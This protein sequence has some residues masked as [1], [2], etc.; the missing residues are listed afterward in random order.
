MPPKSK[1]KRE[2]VLAAAVALVRQSGDV[3]LN[4]R[5]IA[6][7]LHCS[8][9]PIF[10]NFGSMEEVRRAVIAEAM[11]LYAELDR[12]VLASEKYPVYKA[13]GMAY[14]GFAEKEPALFRLLYMRSRTGEQSSPEAPLFGQMANIVQQNTGLDASAAEIFHMEMW[15]VVHGIAAMIATDY[16][17]PDRSLTEAMLTDAYLG[18][19][20]RFE[21]KEDR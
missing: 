12:E 5:A 2:N 21:S 4:A 20:H 6:N 18:L 10:S 11:R 7:A 14:I 16:F 8:T 17:K 9:Q 13:H 19:K 1:I 15:A 3:A